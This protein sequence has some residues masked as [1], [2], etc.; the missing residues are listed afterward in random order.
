MPATELPDGRVVLTR[1]F[2]QSTLYLVELWGGPV[3]VLLP[4]TPADFVTGNLDEQPYLRSDLP[5]DVVVAGFESAAYRAALRDATVVSGCEHY[6]LHWVA[7]FCRRRAITFVPVVENALPNRLRMMAIHEHDPVKRARSFVWTVQDGLKDYVNVF[8]ASSVQCNG[9]PAYDQY[10]WLTRDPLLF[11]DGRVTEDM[12]PTEDAV[13]QRMAARAEGAPLRLAFSGRFADIKGVDHLPDLAAALRTREVPFVLDL[14]GGGPLED[15]VKR[16]V[17]QLGLESQ[18]RLHGVVDFATRLMPL[19]SRDV[20]L[21][22]ACHRQAD[23]SCTYLE[24]FSC[25]VPI[26]G[27]ANGAF[28]GMLREANAG[29]ATPIDDVAALADKI[30]R[31][32]ADRA[33]LERASL[34]ALRFAR[35][36]TFEVTFR[37]RVEHY[38]RAFETR[39]RG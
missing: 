7:A 3:R 15:D 9:T 26:A 17:V 39:P 30:A 28:K 13:R 12:L 16:R 1:K 27:Y 18:V 37:R 35:Q 29:W 8:Q 19:L 6:Q 11:F 2:V 31:L 36:H 33:E 20:D 5:F 10:R 24:T 22:V 23:P 4:P 21:F 38:R 14:Y 25:G 32:S 34:A